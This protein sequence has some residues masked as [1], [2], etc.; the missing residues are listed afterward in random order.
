MD[1]IRTLPNREPNSPRQPQSLLQLC[2]AQLWSPRIETST[3]CRQLPYNHCQFCYLATCH[4][5]REYG[6][7][8]EDIET[9]RFHLASAYEYERTNFLLKC[10]KPLLRKFLTLHILYAK[11]LIQNRA[12]HL[13][14]KNHCWRHTVW[15]RGALHLSYGVAHLRTCYDIFILY[16]GEHLNWLSTADDPGDISHVKIV[17]RILPPLRQLPSHHRRNEVESSGTAPTLTWGYV[18]NELYRDCNEGLRQC[19]TEIQQDEKCMV[20]CVCM[21]PLFLL[22]CLMGGIV[23]LCVVYLW[24]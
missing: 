1:L 8:K 3:V 5:V 12:S 15:Y 7:L 13:F 19:V 24:G 17:C 11:G 16:L 20:F 9:P 18:C 23:Q 4:L 14:Y 6:A 10:T 22:L 2:A 21:M